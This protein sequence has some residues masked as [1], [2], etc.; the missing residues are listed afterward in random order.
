MALKAPQRNIVYRDYFNDLGPAGDAAHRWRDASAGVRE[1]DLVNTRG[2]DSG[3]PDNL[4]AGEE[5]AIKCIKNNAVA[6]V[7]Q[8]RASGMWGSG[9]TLDI[10]KSSG[11]ATIS[12]NTNL[13]D[14]AASFDTSYLGKKILFNTGSQSFFSIIEIVDSNNVTLSEDATALNGLTYWVLEPTHVEM[15][16]YVHEYPDTDG[17]AGLSSEENQRRMR[18]LRPQISSNASNP[19][20]NRVSF[21]IQD[22]PYNQNPPAFQF[23]R[24]ESGWHQ[25]IYQMDLTG[26]TGIDPSAIN[27]MNVTI[28]SNDVSGNAVS[29]ARITMAEVSLLSFDDEPRMAFSTDDGIYQY[30]VGQDDGL[31]R[32]VELLNE[33]GVKGTFFVNPGRIRTDHSR[34]PTGEGGLYCN[35][36]D[37]HEIQDAGHVI[38]NHTWDHLHMYE[39]TQ[40]V[41]PGELLPGYELNG[42]ILDTYLES[43]QLGY[44]FLKTYGFNGYDLLATPFGEMRRDVVDYLEANLPL[45]QI[46]TVY[47]MNNVRPYI[48][49]DSNDVFNYNYWPWYTDPQKPMRIGDID[50]LCL[51]RVKQFQCT[52]AYYIHRFSSASSSIIE[53]WCQAHVAGEIEMITH[54]Q[55]IED[56]PATTSF[57]NMT[58]PTGSR[59]TRL[60]VR[61]HNPLTVFTEWEFIDADGNHFV[62]RTDSN[63]AVNAEN[64]LS[65]STDYI[66][67]WFP[68]YHYYRVRTRQYFAGRWNAWTPYEYFQ[69]RG[70]LNSFEKFYALNSESLTQVD[71]VD[72][73]PEPPIGV[74]ESLNYEDD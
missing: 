11:T 16:W 3:G 51:T 21:N 32:W 48:P 15:W 23:N 43:V 57:T 64:V 22:E 28:Q 12:G 13:N 42:A 66:E 8:S 67:M 63:G 60:I 4:V 17:P 52:T 36:Y 26:G 18:Y 5:S 24:K 14:N 41:Y 44:D 2:V 40:N 61:D 62:I 9:N 19:N 34:E 35:V 47:S 58:Y 33:Y 68:P 45:R 27:L 56:R 49:F 7:I 37:L 1:E 72:I 55:M 31:P 73:T 59:G 50:A 39:F 46:A 70:P 38:A 6:Y 65:A 20:L 30:I 74:D 29:D 54:T 25:T 10:T 71:G 69:T 53:S